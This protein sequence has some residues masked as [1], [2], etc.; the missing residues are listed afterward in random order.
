MATSG[1]IHW[2]AGLIATVVLIGATSPIRAA[3]AQADQAPGALQSLGKNREKPMQIEAASLQLSD[4]DMATAFAGNVQVTLGDSSI[5]CETLV[6]YYESR[7]R[8]GGIKTAEPGPGGARQIR[9]LVA[10]GGVVVSHQHESARGDFGDFEFDADRVTLTGTVTTTDTL[11]TLHAD[12]II[13]DLS[14][15]RSLVQ[16]TRPT[17]SRPLLPL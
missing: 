1:T 8:P 7:D 10:R 3:L 2:L 11:T 12:R 5:R 15:G 16:S 4:R 13:V 17:E 14:T 6:V 9:E